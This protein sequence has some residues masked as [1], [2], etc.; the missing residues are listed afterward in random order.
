M[1]LKKSGV[2]LPDIILHKTVKISKYLLNPRQPRGF[3]SGIFEPE[4]R[5]RRRRTK[6]FHCTFHEVF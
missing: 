3:G 5:K 1:D 6:L 2:N 4:K